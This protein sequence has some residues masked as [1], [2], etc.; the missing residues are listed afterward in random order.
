[1]ERIERDFFA[2]DKEDQQAFLTQTWCN[3]CMEADLGMVEPSEYEVNGVVFVEGKCARCGEPIVTE[4]AD[5]ST[6]GDWD[7]GE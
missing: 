4:I 3:Q 2:R 7:D 6:D 1:M 5:D